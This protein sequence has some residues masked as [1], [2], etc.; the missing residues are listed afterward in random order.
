MGAGGVDR[1]E[2][3]RAGGGAG[4]ACDARRGGGAGASV[5]AA[6]DARR[7]GAAR[8]RQPAA[9]PGGAGGQVWG[10]AWGGACLSGPGAQAARECQSARRN[11]AAAHSPLPAPPRRSIQLGKVALVQPLLELGASL[12][13][14]DEYSHKGPAL[15][16]AASNG[17]V[18]MVRALLEVRA[19]AAGGG[20]AA[21]AGAG[22]AGAGGL[23]GTLLPRLLT[24][25][26]VCRTGG[27]EPQPD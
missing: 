5:R 4:A 23:A 3:H 8:G 25:A 27:G 15:L 20:G 16:H 26:P 19:A 24:R 7:A 1:G 17:H 11:A 14:V 22:G 12:T 9:H 6:Q 2:Q 18:P 21:A 13:A 10:S